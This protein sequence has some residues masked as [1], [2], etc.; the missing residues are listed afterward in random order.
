MNFFKKNKPSLLLRNSYNEIRI[1][2]QAVDLFFKLLIDICIIS[3][4][5]GFILLL[6]A[7]N[8]YNIFNV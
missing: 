8:D 3:N 7:N 6:P 1:F 5:F 4:I 2:I